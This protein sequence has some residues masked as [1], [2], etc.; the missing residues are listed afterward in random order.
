M[1]YARVLP[2]LSDMQHCLSHI[3]QALVSDT[4]MRESLTDSGSDKDST[5]SSSVA[6]STAAVASAQWGNLADFYHFFS[7][8]GVALRASHELVVGSRYE[9]VGLYD[10]S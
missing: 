4:P 10:L 5:Q 1:L 9:Q 3:G 6:A 2:C 8:S 7:A